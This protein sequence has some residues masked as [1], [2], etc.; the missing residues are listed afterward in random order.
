MTGRILGLQ[1][2]FYL[3]FLPSDII[4][5][6][7]WCL[8]ASELVKLC[9][10]HRFFKKILFIFTGEGSET[11]RERNINLW[12]PLLHSLLGTSSNPGMCPDR[13]LNQWPFGLQAW[14]QSTEPHQPGLLVTFWQKMFQHWALFGICCNC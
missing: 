2:S 14:V 10:C 1:S 7:P 6:I 12:L 13:E 4:T 8:W 5:V 3:I 9:T 11:K